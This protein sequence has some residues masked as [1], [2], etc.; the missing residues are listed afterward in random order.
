MLNIKPPNLKSIQEHVSA[1]SIDSLVTSEVS[2]T[3]FDYDT[4]HTQVLFW[5]FL[6]IDFFFISTPPPAFCSRPGIN[7]QWEWMPT[8]TFL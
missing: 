4:Q 1:T 2:G 7:F 5:V 8:L 6:S 3:V